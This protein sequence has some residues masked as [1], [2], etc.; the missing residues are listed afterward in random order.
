MQKIGLK[1]PALGKTAWSAASLEADRERSDI[2][3]NGPMAHLVSM[4]FEELDPI[5][6]KQ[7]H[8]P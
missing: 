1:R 4:F 6:E 7:C 2:A 5:I 8:R 3:T